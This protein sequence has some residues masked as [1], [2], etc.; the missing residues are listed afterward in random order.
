MQFYIFMSTTF[1]VFQSL[2]PSWCTNPMESIYIYILF[3]IEN[4]YGQN[5]FTKICTSKGIMNNICS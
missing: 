5:M 2:K 1:T 3:Q 4:T